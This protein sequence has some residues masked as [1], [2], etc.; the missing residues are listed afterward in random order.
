MVLLGSK[1]Q[2]RVIQGRS[3][4]H[5]QLTSGVDTFDYPHHV[6][7]YG[8]LR[9]QHMPTRKKQS[10]QMVG[11]EKV[12]QIQVE[13]GEAQ[14]CHTPALLEEEEERTFP[15]WAGPYSLVVPPSAEV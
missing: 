5:F 8:I 7:E 3:C 9:L 12:S 14:N 10:T 2:A 15:S 11:L 13:E 4:D 1:F 6:V